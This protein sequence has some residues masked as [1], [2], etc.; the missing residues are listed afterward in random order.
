MSSRDIVY[1]ALFAAVTA[2]LG[3]VPPFMLPIGAGV[4]ISAQSLGPMLAGC[5]LGAR[6]GGLALL[7]FVALV[8]I[9]LP[10]LA[11]GRGGF[12]VIMGPT[13]GF[14]LAYPLVAF[15]IGYLVERNWRHLDLFAA[16][17]ACVVGGILV[18]YLIGVPW[19]AAVAGLPLG[20]AIWVSLAFI[21]GDLIKAALAAVVAVTV[22]K[23]YPLIE[24]KTS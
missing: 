5:V 11:G 2:V 14:F 4:P 8:A 21:P 22:K 23:S 19:M 6:R 20:Q 10:L 1:V 9:G 3:L 13:G 18:L 7:L 24:L 17:L 12:G 16:G 15:I